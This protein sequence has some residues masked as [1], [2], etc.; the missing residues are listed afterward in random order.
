MYK[1]VRVDYKAK[2]Q[3][4]FNRDDNHFAREFFNC[5]DYRNK[6]LPDSKEATKGVKNILS[7][8]LYE[9]R[10]KELIKQRTA[11]DKCRIYTIRLSLMLLS[12]LILLVGWVVIIL[13]SFY[14]SEITDFFKD[15]VVVKSISTYVGAIVLTIVNY[16][17]PK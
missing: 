6:R 9:D 10:K 14:E 12:I 4:F 16:I 2:R 11:S 1:W 5:W 8:M 17:V 15:I 7:I 3:R 13:A